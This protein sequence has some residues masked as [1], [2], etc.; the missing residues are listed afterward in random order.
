MNIEY[1]I[2][3]SSYIQIYGE[4]NIILG[5]IP[6]NIDDMLLGFTSSSVTVR[7]GNFINVYDKHGT[8]ISSNSI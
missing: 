1:A 3:K 5:S 7:K 4:N 8:L 2:E 6:T